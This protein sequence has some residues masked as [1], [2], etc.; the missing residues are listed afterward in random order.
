MRSDLHLSPKSHL[1]HIVEEASHMSHTRCI[2]H[3]PMARNEEPVFTSSLPK[4]SNA[5][6]SLVHFAFATHI[7]KQIQTKYKIHLV[8]LTLCTSNKS[9]KAFTQAEAG[10]ALSDTVIIEL[11]DVSRAIRRGATSLGRYR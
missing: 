4:S 7:F 9:S 10:P 1:M 5:R 11:L 3:R 6:I 8:N 2:C